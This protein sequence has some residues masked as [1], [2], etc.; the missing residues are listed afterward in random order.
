MFGKFKS[1][2]GIAPKSSE[3][4]TTFD[5]SD[6]PIGEFGE[7]A[8]FTKRV[9]NSLTTYYEQLP[10]LEKYAAT[11]QA[12]LDYINDK[13]ENT[14]I[15]EGFKTKLDEM[16]NIYNE[17]SS[18]RSLVSD[19]LKY[20]NEEDI[21]LLQ[22]IKQFDTIEQILIKI[23]T[24]QKALRAVELISTVLFNNKK[25]EFDEKDKYRDDLLKI[26]FIKHIY[27][28][29]QTLSGGGRPKKSRRQKSKRRQLSKRRSSNRRS[30]K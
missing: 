28:K 25:Y 27:E 18:F 14:D 29:G 5:Y 20:N 3:P 17:Y 2:I 6:K 16:S 12:F 15:D 10:T 11:S 19:F 8:G 24:I 21:Q 23:A 30:K 22:D 7:K 26:V 13:G 1:L 4:E 9:N